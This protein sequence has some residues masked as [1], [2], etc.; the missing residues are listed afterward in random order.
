MNIDGGLGGGIH[1]VVVFNE[2]IA[3]IDKVIGCGPIFDNYTSIDKKVLNENE[4]EILKFLLKEMK[5]RGD[6]TTLLD[7]YVCDDGSEEMELF[8]E[9]GGFKCRA[10]T[11]IPRDLNT[12]CSYVEFLVKQ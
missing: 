12:L 11:S 2:G 7:R 5:S 9:M 8:G 4:T 10:E 3:T 1:I 6:C